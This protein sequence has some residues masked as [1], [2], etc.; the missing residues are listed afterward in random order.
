MTLS[1]VQF[2]NRKYFRT[3]Y[4]GVTFNLIFIINWSC[5]YEE[6]W[7]SIRL[8]GHKWLK[9]THLKV[10]ELAEIG[11]TPNDCYI[12]E[13]KKK[14]IRKIFVN[15]LWFF[16]AWK[17]SPR[18][19]MCESFK[20]ENNELFNFT[21]SIGYTSS[22]FR[23]KSLKNQKKWMY[24][25]WCGTAW[26]TFKCDYCL[27]LQFFHC[28]RLYLFLSHFL[29]CFMKYLH[30]VLKHWNLLTAKSNYVKLD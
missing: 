3:E 1:N 17:C 12:F 19:L 29:F 7:Q 25:F 8:M 5:L 10:T 18:L 4:R 22:T 30:F 24:K 27:M 26:R 14:L 15:L 6:K 21:N 11:P 20:I 9:R 13:E 2:R 16:F 28:L 23:E